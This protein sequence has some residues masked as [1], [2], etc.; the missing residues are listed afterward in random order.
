MSN[1]ASNGTSVHAVSHD[2]QR[3][4]SK[5]TP[6]FRASRVQGKISSHRDHQVA[7]P[8]YDNPHYKQ[9]QGKPTHWMSTKSC[10]VVYRLM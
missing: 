3:F 7:G 1:A 9:H 4:S 2:S 10:P 6:R 8:R 5:H